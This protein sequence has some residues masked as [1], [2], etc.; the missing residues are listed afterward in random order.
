M[1]FPPWV[2]CALALNTGSSAQLPARIPCLERRVSRQPS[3]PAISTVRRLSAKLF[4]RRPETI[5]N[6]LTIHIVNERRARRRV[7]AVDAAT[8]QA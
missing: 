8:L 7:H 3:A 5:F 1:S 4:G 2:F 6:V